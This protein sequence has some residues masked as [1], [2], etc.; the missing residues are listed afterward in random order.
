[1]LQA[2]DVAGAIV[3]RFGG[4]SI[5]PREIVV[6]DVR[7]PCIGFIDS[8]DLFDRC[9]RRHGQAGRQIDSV[10]KVFREGRQPAGLR[11]IGR[12]K[13]R[14][15]G[16]IHRSPPRVWLNR[17][18]QTRKPCRSSTICMAARGAALHRHEK[19]PE[20]E[21][22]FTIEPA[23]INRAPRISQCGGKGSACLAS[24][25]PASS[26]NFSHP[27][28]RRGRSQPFGGRRP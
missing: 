13:D 5:R 23:F 27:T 14:A 21:S 9:D 6:D 15:H 7:D 19:H 1:M 3:D 24:K 17:R 8:T 11:R 20:T 16:I 25:T 2:D 4:K 22:G 12:D 28:T 26:Q 18:P 10:G